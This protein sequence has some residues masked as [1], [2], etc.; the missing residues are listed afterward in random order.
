M[1]ISIAMV[2]RRLTRSLGFIVKHLH[3][4]PHSL[5]E[6]QRQIRIDQSIELL[7][8]LESAQANDWQRFMTLDEF[9]FYL[10]TSHE[11]VWVQAGQQ[12]PEMVKHMIGDS[13]MMVTIVWDPQCFHLVDALPK[14][15]KFNANYYIDRILQL[16]LESRSTGRG[17]G[18]IIHADN[19]RSHTARKTFKFCRENRLEI[20]P[21]PPYSPDLALSDF[22]L[23][24]HV[25]HA[26]EGAEFSS[27]ETL[28]AAILRV[29]SDLTGDILRAV[30]AKWVEQLN[31]VAL[32][33]GHYYR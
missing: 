5:I 1:C 14:G 28:L 6:A 10:W 25:K 22:F 3:W 23:F 18:L 32:N 33:E 7:R 11:I 29:L 24:G 19:A 20:A 17:P 15:Q 31:L 27:E 30:F 2:W 16:L 9:W 12:P 26:L 13:K 4:A 21:H 8:R